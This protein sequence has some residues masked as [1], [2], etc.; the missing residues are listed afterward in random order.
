M[1]KN[2]FNI[3]YFW[4][5]ICNMFFKVIMFSANL[6]LNIFKKYLFRK[7]RIFTIK[8]APD[9]NVITASLNKILNEPLSF[10]WRDMFKNILTG[11]YVKRVFL[12]GEFISTLSN[13]GW[14]VTDRYINNR[15]LVLR[16]ELFNREPWFSLHGY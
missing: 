7:C 8:W 15:C 4:Q 12:K 2:L 11:N 14:N 1:I 16:E 10:F 13:I 9:N 5:T 6:V 3:L